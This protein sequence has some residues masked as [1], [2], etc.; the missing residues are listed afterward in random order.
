MSAQEHGH[1]HG[2]VKLA[3]VRHARLLVCYIPEYNK[4]HAC[5]R[6]AYSTILDYNKVSGRCMDRSVQ[7]VG[8]CI[9]AT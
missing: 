2:D 7:V 4:Q 6:H 9:G 3:A 5:C 1:G 8:G